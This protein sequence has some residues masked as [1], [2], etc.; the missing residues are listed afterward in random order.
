VILGP[1]RQA[2]LSDLLAWDRDRIDA[3]IATGVNCSEYRAL[4]DA[5]ALAIP[6]DVDTWAQAVRELF[7]EVMEGVR[8][9][10]ETAAGRHPLLRQFVI[11]GLPAMTRARKI[12]FFLLAVDL[13]ILARLREAARAEWPEREEDIP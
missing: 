8:H 2:L 5:A 11:P 1:A 13:G 7:Q 4:Q 3:I 6:T 12:L 9:A 10:A